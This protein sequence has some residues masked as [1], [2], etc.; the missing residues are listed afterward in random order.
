M[1]LQSIHENELKEKLDKLAEIY[2]I[3]ET[4]PCVLARK[5]TIVKRFFIMELD[6]HFIKDYFD[7]KFVAHVNKIKKQKK[8]TLPQA[9]AI[10]DTKIL[11]SCCI[12]LI[13]M[14][15]IIP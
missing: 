1:I 4:L 6:E 3:F 8:V 7:P 2:S 9:L 10:K 15:E 13:H 14:N 11:E 5:I 12:S